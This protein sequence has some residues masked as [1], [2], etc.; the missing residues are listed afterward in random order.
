M[1]W[2]SDLVEKHEG[3]GSSDGLG[4]ITEAGTCSDGLGL[5]GGRVWIPILEK[6]LVCVF[7]A[8][9]LG[10]SHRPRWLVVVEK[11][12][13]GGLGDGLGSIT[14]IV[15]IS[16]RVGIDKVRDGHILI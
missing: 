6:K 11:N 9:I 13:S 15:M 5:D 1:P 16:N 4:F 2:L 3:S 12:E 10:L 14:I 7:L 8:M